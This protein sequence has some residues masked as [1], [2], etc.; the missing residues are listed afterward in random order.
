MIHK[1]REGLGLVFHLIRLKDQFLHCLIYH[2]SFLHTNL[3]KEEEFRTKNKEEK[4]G[5]FKDRCLLNTP[6]LHS[7]AH[8]NQAPPVPP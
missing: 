8:L 6:H 2:P 5:G 7:E 4:K 3:K 1:K